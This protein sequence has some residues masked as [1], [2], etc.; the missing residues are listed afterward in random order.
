[1]HQQDVFTE[2]ALQSA[3]DPNPRRVYVHW[4]LLKVLQYW[5]E[6]STWVLAPRMC[7]TLTMTVAVL[8]FAAPQYA[9][10]GA[11][12]MHAGSLLGVETLHDEQ[13]S[14]WMFNIA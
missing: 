11:L 6:Q 8:I 7:D 2:E 5:S 12:S 14:G 9:A 1:M 10:E 3:R 4:A 13:I